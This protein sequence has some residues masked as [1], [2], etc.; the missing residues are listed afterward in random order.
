MASASG[1]AAGVGG[2][3]MGFNPLL[4]AGL[5]SFAPGLLSKLFGGDPQQKLRQEIA[6]LL[7]SRGQRTNQLYQQV[8][9][10]PAFSQAQGTIA[11]GANQASGNLASSL[12]ARGIGTTGTGAVLSSL[13]PSLVGSQQAGLRTSAYNT[14][15]SQADQ[16]IQAQIA[17]LTGTAGPSQSTQLFA[18]GLSAFGPM[19]SQWLQ[20]R[21]PK[22]AG[23]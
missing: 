13:L 5:L 16:D 2:A 11:S 8:Q 9:G 1:T 18:G 4:L 15:A 19:L 21:Y 22:T 17:A 10:S 7:A 6:K 3:A 14:A 20:S 23:Y 12:A